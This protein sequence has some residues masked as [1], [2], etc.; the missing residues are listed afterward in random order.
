MDSG[1]HTR[2]HS[3]CMHVEKVEGHLPV[4]LVACLYFLTVLY[5]CN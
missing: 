3:R 2:F 1:T 5:C 4:G